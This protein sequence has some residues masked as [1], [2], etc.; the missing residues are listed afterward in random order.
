ME[1]AKD[2]LQRKWVFQIIATIK[3][4]PRDDRGGKQAALLCGPVGAAVNNDRS[5]FHLPGWG[6]SI[7]NVKA[8]REILEVTGM[9][10]LYLPLYSTAQISTRLRKCDPR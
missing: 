4:S 1:T 7:C 5:F 10:A 8:V 2:T 6:K 3:K 9:K